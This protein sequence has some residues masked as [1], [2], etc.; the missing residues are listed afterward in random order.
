MSLIVREGVEEM[1]EVEGGAAS[2]Y[3]EPSVTSL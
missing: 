2:N 3:C 1:E